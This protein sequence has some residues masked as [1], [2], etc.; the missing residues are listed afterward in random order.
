[1]KN[2]NEVICPNCF[3]SEQRQILATATSRN[4]IKDDESSDP[5]RKGRLQRDREGT[6]VKMFC[7]RCG[8]ELKRKGNRV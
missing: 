6:L 2:R 3:G 4:V 7:S 5:E 1:M 8:H